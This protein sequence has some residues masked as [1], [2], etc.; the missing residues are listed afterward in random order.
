MLNKTGPSTDP[1]GTQ[2]SHFKTTHKSLFLGKEMDKKTCSHCC[3]RTRKIEK[4]ICQK[5]AAF[6]VETKC[7]LS[8]LPQLGT[9]PHHPPPWPSVPTQL[10]FLAPHLPGVADGYEELG[11]SGRSKYVGVKRYPRMSCWRQG[12]HPRSLLLLGNS[13]ATSAT[14]APPGVLDRKRSGKLLAV[15]RPA[16]DRKQNKHCSEKW[17]LHLPSLCI[18]QIHI[19][20]TWHSSPTCRAIQPR[21]GGREDKVG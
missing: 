12:D 6:L 21:G 14:L 8:L 3:Y 11:Q 2:N 20:L 5:Q 7:A 19:Y 1:W 4:N 15:N 9:I 16:E 10:L 13:T 18:W 17:S